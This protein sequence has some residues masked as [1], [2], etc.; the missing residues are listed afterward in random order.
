MPDDFVTLSNRLLNRCP[1][2][3][4][5]LCEQFV[6][7]AWKTLQSRREWSWR[8]RSSTFAPPDIYA[9]GSVSTNVGIGQPT[10]LTGIGTVWTPSMIGR[11]IRVGGVLYPYY[12]IT[13]W[14]SATSILIDQPWAGPDVTLKP[15]QMLQCYFTVPADFGY[16]L[17]VV[18]VKDG[19]R[20]W[21]NMTQTDLGLM[22]PQRVNTGQTYA[23]AFRDYQ[24]QLS[25]TVGPVIPVSAT[26]ASPVST[27]SLGFSYV[28][29]ATY[30][31][32]VATTGVSGAATFSWM[33]SGQTGFTGPILTDIAA[34]DLM[35]GVQVYWPAGGAVYTAGDLFII[36]ARAGSVSGSVRY[37]LWP[38][39]TTSAYLYP[40]LYL[41]RE[42]DLTVGQPQLPYPVAA[43]G[44]VLL[45][46]AL[47]SCARF[48][49]PDTDHPNPYF[50]LTLAVQHDRRALELIYDL[51]RNDEETG[52]SNVSYQEYPFYP[53]PWL[54]GHWQQ[55]HSPFLRG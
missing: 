34:A 21:T 4:I 6:N 27:T 2:A 40:Y 20:L 26:G 30:I 38:A 24:Q 19:Y 1:A 12:T 53:A 41:A 7:D 54:D 25:G 18:S 23:T 43:R 35:D 52:V 16:F 15:Y 51:E 10:L 14:L 33:R 28:A 8:R 42:Y 11:Q 55:S 39:P 45:E 13:A 44:E 5:V 9:T 37:E 32:R 31:I 3:G 50:N 22:D 46:M 17:V 49:G 36:N 47:A 29:D 48:P